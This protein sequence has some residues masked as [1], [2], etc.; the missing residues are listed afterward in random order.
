M[1]PAD[2]Y[3]RYGLPGRHTPT[4]ARS[5]Q[6]VDEVVAYWR[7]L[8]S[9][10]T[11]AALADALL[12]AHAELER[13][14]QLTAGEV[15]QA[16]RRT[17]AARRLDAAGRLAKA[18]AGDGHRRA[19]ARWPGCG[20]A[21]GGVRHRR[22]RARGAQPG[23]VR[24][25]E[26]VPRAARRRMPQPRDLSGSPTSSACGCRPRSSSATRCATASAS[27]AASGSPT[28]GGS[29]RPRSPRRATRWPRCRHLGSGQ[30]AGSR[31]CW[32][33]CARPP[34]TRRSSTRCCC[35]RSS[36][37]CGSSPTAG[38]SSGPS[39]PR[40]GNS[41]WSRTR[42][43]C[44]RPRSGP[45]H[46]R[47]GAPAGRSRSWP[48]AGCAPRSGWPPG[49]PRRIR[50]ASASRAGR[51]G[52]RA[53]PAGRP[54]S[55]RGGTEQ[56]A[57]LLAEAIGHG[58]RRRRRL[59]RPAAAALP[60]PPPATRPAS[61]GTRCWSPGSPARRWPAGCGTGSCAGWA[62]RPARPPRARWSAATDSAR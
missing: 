55:G 39:P 22:R 16:A 4:A 54:R 27:S 44:W 10:R 48:A 2:L 20:G 17:P 18:G 51:R 12:A 58:Q 21:L 60:P 49:C 62:G 40:P 25:V 50:C 28:G 33:S 13:A 61:S 32:P 52:Q 24:V 7:E 59:P 1:P 15:R 6:Q 45:G 34:A 56:A 8:K 29:T 42:P 9:R 38:S 37:G 11:Y 23:G 57:A 30:G 46:G 3:V 41:A 47:R 53:H 31:T 43:A 14:G 26:R 36:N 35:P 5:P 19:R